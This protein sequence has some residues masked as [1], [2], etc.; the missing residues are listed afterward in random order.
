MRL[1]PAQ[2]GMQALLGA[3]LPMGMPRDWTMRQRVKH[4]HD[5]LVTLARVDLGYD[6]LAWHDHLRET[7][8]GGYRWSNKHIGIP[9]QIQLAKAR[10]EWQEAVAE[11]TQAT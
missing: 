1:T 10:P 3:F 7:N 4:G 2:I 11:L 8:A 9:K 5:Y 6:P